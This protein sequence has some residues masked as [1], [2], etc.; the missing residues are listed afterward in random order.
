MTLSGQAMPRIRSRKVER[1]QP[2]AFG[3]A[4]LMGELLDLRAES[5]RV[6][7]QRFDDV[8]TGDQPGGAGGS[9]LF[10]FVVANG[11]RSRGPAAGW[12]V[13]RRADRPHSERFRQQMRRL[14]HACAESL[15]TEVQPDLW[16]AAGAAP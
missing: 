12:Q 9:N 15:R 11:E 3:A 13:A 5:R 4:A 1:V 2:R 14:E 7:E 6:M 16:N 10:E 8:R